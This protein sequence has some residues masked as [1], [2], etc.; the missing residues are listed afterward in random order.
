MI[1][2]SIPKR[3]SAPNNPNNP[4]QPD[5]GAEVE[6]DEEQEVMGN[7]VAVSRMNSTPPPPEPPSEPIDPWAYNLFGGECR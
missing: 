3:R 1:R 4:N 7:E 5:A 2:R 6:I